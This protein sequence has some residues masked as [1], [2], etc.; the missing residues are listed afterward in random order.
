MFGAAAQNR[1]IM[2]VAMLGL[3]AALILAAFALSASLV[4]AQSSPAAP[5]NLT[6]THNGSAV[7]ATWD[8]DSGAT[9]YH[10][11][12]SVDSMNSWSGPACGDGCIATVNGNQASFTIN[13]ADPAKTYVVGLRAGNDNGWSAWVNSAPATP[14]NPPPAA[15]ANVKR[16]PL[17]RHAQRLRI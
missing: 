9:K 1:R 3:A 7:T 17:R 12:Y 15:P 8:A 16:D 6:A 11:T 2:H 5:T 10:I 13:G 4:A 14:P